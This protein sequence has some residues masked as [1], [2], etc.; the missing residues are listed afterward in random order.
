M[1]GHKHGRVQALSTSVQIIYVLIVDVEVDFTINEIF[2]SPLVYSYTVLHPHGGGGELLSLWQ[3]VTQAYY[4]LFVSICHYVLALWLST[5]SWFGCE[6][7]VQCLLG[8]P[9]IFVMVLLCNCVIFLFRPSC[10]YYI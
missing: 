8:Y 4:A 5:A 7:D 10:T 3:Q 2:K 6:N 9:S 1:E